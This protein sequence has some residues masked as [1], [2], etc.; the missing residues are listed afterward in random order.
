ML[1]RDQKFNVVLHLVITSILHPK[2]SLFIGRSVLRDSAAL[3]SLQQLLR[4]HPSAHLDEVLALSAAVKAGQ[5]EA[6]KL[7]LKVKADPNERD[8]KGVPCARSVRDVC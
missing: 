7:L 6:T 4:S 8:E 5:L 1:Y 2:S 3:R